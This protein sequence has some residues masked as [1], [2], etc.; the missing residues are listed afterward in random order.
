MLRPLILAFLLPLAPV[1]SLAQTVVPQS[2]TVPDAV[3]RFSQTLMIGPVMEVMREEGLKYGTSL[4]DEMFPQRGGAAW[5]ATVSQIYNAQAMQ[6]TFDARLAKELQG[7]PDDLAAM[8]AFLGSDRGQRI[9]TLELEARRTMLDDAATEAAKALVSDMMAQNTPRMEALRKFTRT[10]DLIEQNVAGALNANLAF[11]QG[12][13]AGGAFEDAMPE[14]E[15]L[16]DV[17]SQEEQVRSD[18]TEWLY[19]YLALAYQPLSDD[20][21][22]AYQAF[23]ESPAGQAMNAAMFASFD[24]VFRDISRTLGAAAARQMQGEDI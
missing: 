8:Q 20:D 5:A 2:Q 13:S 4:E 24:E 21:L 6:Q 17:W 12:M 10:N 7:R 3:S 19:S 15:M 16:S 11:Y 14:D 18:T 1:A 22:A 23:S 9:L